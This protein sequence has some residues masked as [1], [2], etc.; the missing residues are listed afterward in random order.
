MIFEP[1]NEQL[2]RTE[3]DILETMDSDPKKAMERDDLERISVAILASNG[4]PNQ[5]PHSDVAHMAAGLKGLNLKKTTIF[6][7]LKNIHDLEAK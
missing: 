5:P 4:A 6:A 1:N 3:M 2:A 7:G